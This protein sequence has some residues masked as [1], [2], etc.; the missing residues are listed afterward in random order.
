MAKKVGFPGNVFSLLPNIVYVNNKDKEGND[1]CARPSPLVMSC[2]AGMECTG[3]TEFVVQQRLDTRNA[4]QHALTLYLLRFTPLTAPCRPEN[5]DDDDDEARCFPQTWREGEKSQLLCLLWQRSG[6]A[7]L[8]AMHSGHVAPPAS[9]SRSVMRAVGVSN[10][11]SAAR[12][13]RAHTTAPPV[14]PPLPC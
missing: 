2:P 5:G 11:A 10:A 7:S 6:S 8:A 9:N 3:A 13:M 14:L 12:E 4:T 1:E